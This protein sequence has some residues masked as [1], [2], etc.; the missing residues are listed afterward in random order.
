MYLAAL[1]L[2]GSAVFAGP[3]SADLAQ[4]RSI[5]VLPMASG[6]DQYLANRLTQ[7][8]RFQIVTDAQAADAVLT[9]R[10]GEALQAKLEELY[11][12]PAPPAPPPAAKEESAEDRTAEETATE[13]P[14]KPRRAGLGTWGR[15]RGNVF[16]VDR[17]SRRVIWSDYRKP[18]STE[19]DE[20]D[21]LAEYFAGRLRKDAGAFPQS[22]TGNSPPA[23][24]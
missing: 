16:L 11:P 17:T 1:F 21:R 13:E 23:V 3:K 8:G 7:T 24:P 5:Y 14:E 19:S 2:A 15:G 6:L 12:P 4:V 20:L 22:M 10:I 9:D 18:R